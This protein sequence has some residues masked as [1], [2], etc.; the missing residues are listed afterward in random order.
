MTTVRVILIPFGV[1][2]PKN[3]LIELFFKTNNW[4]LLEEKLTQITPTIPKIIHINFIWESP[5]VFTLGIPGVFTLGNPWGIY[6]MIS[7]LLVY[8]PGHH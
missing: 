1:L 7:T 8:C 4:Y 5:R 6:A 3:M 2:S